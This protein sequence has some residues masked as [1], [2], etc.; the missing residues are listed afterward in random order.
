MD[1][2][3]EQFGG[4]AVGRVGHHVERPTGEAEVGGVSAHDPDPVAEL[5]S[6]RGRTTIVALDGD[7]PS[8][9]IEQ[10]PRER[11]E[12]RTHVEHQVAAAHARCVDQALSPGVVELVPTPALPWLSHGSAPS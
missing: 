6:E 3:R 1:Q 5:G 11:A 4:H 7:D 9:A 10:R 12:A 8:A 2:A